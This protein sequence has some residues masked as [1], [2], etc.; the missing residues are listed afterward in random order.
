[1]T[2]DYDFMDHEERP[3]ARRLALWI[4]SRL[5]GRVVDLGAGTGVY[6]EELQRFGLDA[7]GY[8]IADPQARPD[9]VITQSMLT[10]TD[11]ADVVMCIE[12]AEHIDRQQSSAV[13]ASIW[14]NTLP[15]G[16]VIFSAAQPGQGGVGHINCQPPEYWRDYA[17]QQ[18]FESATE[19]QQDMM[20]WITSGY[21]MGWFRQ[22]GQVWH[23]PKSL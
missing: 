5:R 12:V 16:H 10:V 19:L 20:S 7:Q 23:R 21:H 22:N 1:M 18:G 2:F 14:R 13:I 4:D 6:V 3:F 8:D 11:P 9:L 15:G 17:W